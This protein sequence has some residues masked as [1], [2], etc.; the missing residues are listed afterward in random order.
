MDMGTHPVSSRFGRQKAAPYAA[1]IKSPSYKAR[2]G[3]NTGV[4][5][6]VTTGKRRMENLM[7]Q[8]KDTIGADARYFFFSFF[9]QLKNANL[10]A[11]PVWWKADLNEPRSL[12]SI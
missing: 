3:V 7:K 8:T 1:Y 12:I 5:L 11:D 4:W 6:I 2:F 10:V 9:D